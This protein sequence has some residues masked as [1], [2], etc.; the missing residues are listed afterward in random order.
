MPLWVKTNTGSTPWVK[1]K[2]FWIK[3]N[4][5]GSTPWKAI[6]TA[7]VKT[8][9]GL[10]GW[11]RFFPTTGPYA[12]N[13]PYL[14]SDSAGNVI[15]N[16][17]YIG[18]MPN[19]SA[20]LG[21]GNV[22]VPNKLYGHVGDWNPNDYTISS[23][24][25]G[26]SGFSNSTTN[27]G[28]VVLYNSTSSLSVSN[29]T[30][31]NFSGDKTST[32]VPQ[33]LLN[34]AYDNQYLSFTVTA[35]TTTSGVN[36][37]DSSD[38]G[39]Y[40]RI[41][42]IKHPPVNL[43]ASITAS[44]YG[45][46]STLTMTSYWQTADGYSIDT[47]R[48]AYSWYRA[49]SNSYS[50]LSQLQS[51]ATLLSG[52][53][54]S[55]LTQ[56]SDVGFYIYGV[57]TCYNGGSDYFNAGVGTSVVAVT[58]QKIS[59]GVTQLTSPR[60][61]AQ[62]SSGITKTTGITAG[63][64]FVFTPGTYNNA[65]YIGTYVQW[66]LTLASASGTH[67]EYVGYDGTSPHTISVNEAS[68]QYYFI[69]RDIVI[70]ND[71]NSYDFFGNYYQVVQTPAAAPTF[72]TVTPI[73]GGFTSS[74]NNY[75]Q[76]YGT[77]YTYSLKS[78]TSTTTPVLTFGTS[79]P[80]AYYYPFTVSNM[81]QGSS[82]TFTITANQP[83]YSPSSSDI[84]GSTV[85]SPDNFSYYLYDSS[86]VPDTPSYV[87]IYNN[88][89]NTFYVYWDPQSSSTNVDFWVAYWSGVVSGTSGTY[90]KS[91]QRA[92]TDNISFSSSGSEN[93]YV[94][95]YGNSVSAS[96]DVS[97]Q[98]NANSWLIN[99]SI[100]GLNSGTG[101]FSQRVYSM[102]YKINVS[103]GNTVSINSVQ[104]SNNYYST[105]GSAGY[106][107]S[108]KPSLNSVIAYAQPVEL[109]SVQRP[110]A[111]SPYPIIQR[112]LNS[113]YLRVSD[114]G[115]WSG[116]PTSYRYQWYS[117]NDRG[118]TVAVGS[119]SSLYDYGLNG[120]NTYF[121]YVW[122]SNSQGESLYAAVSNYII[123]S[124][125]SLSSPSIS[126]VTYNAGTFTVYFSGGSGPYYEIWWQ[127]GPGLYADDNNSPDAS[128]A[129]SPISIGLSGTVGTTYYWWVRSSSTLGGTGTGNVSSWSGPYSITVTSTPAP[130]PAPTPAPGPMP[131]S[132]PPGRY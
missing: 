128:G 66:G 121:V 59:A 125:S 35:N 124:G 62:T 32:S 52:S 92:Y 122:A 41:L 126:N 123:P 17:I 57:A 46:G 67:S 9:A 76:S 127:Y 93:A 118:A 98:N 60:L 84:T 20:P 5:G 18:S 4:D 8:S 3:T 36:G 13:Y 45:S 30:D 78:T 83:G 131:S 55:Y 97:T 61:V 89:N 114:N 102:P 90:L 95:A 91:N 25:Y 40:G 2:T 86:A 56:S 99:Y 12:E 87:V 77:Y 64:K 68:N 51:N 119:N 81:S 26:I 14:S 72:G 49:S 94:K 132:N 53:S 19:P 48:T 130:A 63:D 23:F 113:T 28:A 115:T 10:G 116:N 82:A 21:S 96:V 37:S 120:S 103:Y 43:S 38:E 50:T 69:V 6:K 79:I 71:N 100:T 117:I 54:N 110:V 15:P 65:S 80:Q 16:Y 101:S 11:K 24:D 42:T 22:Y 107:T 108:V 1:T 29:S 31:T 44:S 73:A 7:Y 34:A 129:S 39:N 106:Q 111:S 104:A 27:L 47:N 112:V 85:M 109:T 70:G 58:S 33:I 74:I 88:G 105:N 75:T